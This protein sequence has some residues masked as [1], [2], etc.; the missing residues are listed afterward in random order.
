MSETPQAPGWWIASDGR[1]Y[2]PE[3]HPSR[4]S[5]PLPALTAT[6]TSRR[7]S[8]WLLIS[9]AGVVVLALVA[10]LGVTLVQSSGLG[11]LRAGSAT[12]SVSWQKSASCVTTFT[13]TVAGLSLSGTATGV[14]PSS[15]TSNRAGCLPTPTTNPQ[16]HSLPISLLVSRWTGTLGGTAFDVR[17]TLEA[18]SAPKPPGSSATLGHIAGTFGNEPVQASITTSG[19]ETLVFTGTIGHFSV[20]G[21]LTAQSF[22][23]GRLTANFTLTH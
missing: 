13:G 14:F 7:P 10:Y 2:P 20:R 17:V 6:P 15:P 3:L 4:R 11:A 22:S 16:T 1:W 21:T 23:A 8:R 19:R 9:G 12:A 18:T 5:P